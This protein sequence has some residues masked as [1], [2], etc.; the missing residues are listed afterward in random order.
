[1]KDDGVAGRSYP[2]VTGKAGSNTAVNIPSPQIIGF[3]YGLVST[4]VP[5]YA[6]P[7]LQPDSSWVIQQG[8]ANEL[9][10]F[11]LRDTEYPFEIDCYTETI[12]SAQD[13]PTKP[14]ESTDRK[15][16]MGYALST[17]T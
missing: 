16:N 4:K 14:P 3:H 12:Q 7:A 6:V 17:F 13:N 2:N 9:N 15:Y 10:I 5:I 1:M 11:Y 8:Q